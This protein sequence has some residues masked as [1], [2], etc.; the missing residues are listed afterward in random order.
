MITFIIV[1]ITIPAILR[2]AYS[3]NFFD[4]P[5]RRRV[6]KIKTPILGGMGI[7]LGILFTYLFYLDLF[8]YHSVPFLIPALLIIF[9]IGIK[10]D[11]FATTPIMKFIGQM[12][13]VLIIIGFGDLRITDFHGFFAIKPDYFL[14]LFVT[15]ILMIYII[16]GFNLI[17][18]IDG[19]AAI[20]GIITTISFSVWFLI[21]GEYLIPILGATIVGAL[22]AF[23]YYN[24]FSKSQKI[25][26]GDTGSLILGFLISVIAIKFM[27][28]NA[29]ANRPYLKYQMTAAP[30]VAM[31]I[32]IVPVIDTLRVFFRR[33]AR[34]KSP[35]AADK[36]HIHHRLLSL[37]FSHAQTTFMIAGVNIM[38]VILSYFM[39]DF[40]VIFPLAINL[41]VGL[42]VFN[43]PSFAIRMKKKKMRA[44]KS[45]NQTSFKEF[46]NKNNFE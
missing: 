1:F 2:V 15:L 37:G 6:N 27:E 16:N 39:K 36:T 44:Q 30:A 11:I 14:S 26:M 21:N 8:D 35:F 28:M 17:D 4:E 34:G 5:N 23:L 24:L 46:L 32:M 43:I 12:L 38:F 41:T 45:E 25:F 10:D 7:F 42:I 33:I 40:G 3:K 31:G 18:G 22:L 9:A 19:L 29:F 20:T 13:A